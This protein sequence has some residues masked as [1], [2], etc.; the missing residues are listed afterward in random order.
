MQ[1][2]RERDELQ[3]VSFSG[4]SIVEAGNINSFDK[5]TSNEQWQWVQEDTVETEQVLLE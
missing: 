4:D 1:L 5:E 2:L 3:R